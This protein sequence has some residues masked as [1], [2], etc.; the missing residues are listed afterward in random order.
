MQAYVDGKP[1]VD[2]N[3]EKVPGPWWSWDDAVNR[4]KV[5]PVKKPMNVYLAINTGMILA[6]EPESAPDRSCQNQ[7]GSYR[8]IKT[9]E[10]EV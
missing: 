3:G 8:L 9:I 6:Y 4:Y 1:I 7:F 10:V 2:V 5:A